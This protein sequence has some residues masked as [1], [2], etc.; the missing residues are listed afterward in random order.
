MQIV[1]AQPRAQPHVHARAPAHTDIDA[2]TAENADSIASRS[3]NITYMTDV[4]AAASL[5]AAPRTY[6]FGPLAFTPVAAFNR[7]SGLTL[8]IQLGYSVELQAAGPQAQKLLG[9]KPPLPVRYGEYLHD[10][11]LIDGGLEMGKRASAPLFE[12]RYSGGE[13]REGA[14]VL[15]GLFAVVRVRCAPCDNGDEAASPLTICRF[16]RVAHGCG[17]VAELSLSRALCPRPMPMLRMGLDVG[18]RRGAADVAVDGVAARAWRQ[19]C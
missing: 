7:S 10:F 2:D 8:S 3:T 4:S 17:V 18:S 1:L 9:D 6:D 12:Q 11:S 14:R 16:E 19:G 13:C 15:G 5:R